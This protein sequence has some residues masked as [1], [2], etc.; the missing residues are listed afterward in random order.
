MVIW[1]LWYTPR[2]WT[3]G[4]YIA[5]FR[6]LSLCS[7]HTSLATE[8]LYHSHLLPTANHVP[9]PP[10]SLTLHI[11]TANTLSTANCTRYIRPPALRAHAT[12]F[13]LA[14]P[15]SISLSGYSM[16]VALS[17][18]FIRSITVSAKNESIYLG[19]ML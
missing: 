10:F 19:G 14:P 15:H 7:V 18:S 5:T 11:T 2:H 6:T 8:A 13:P 3:Y 16:S 12:V 9:L 1:E 17:A 4:V